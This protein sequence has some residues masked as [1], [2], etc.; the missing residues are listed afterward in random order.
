MPANSSRW[1]KGQSGNPGGR[2]KMPSELR[3][4][5]I[6][7][8]FKCFEVLKRIMCDANEKTENVLKAVAMILDRAFG[9]VV[10]SA[11]EDDIQEKAP[12]QMNSQEWEAVILDLVE[13]RKKAAA[14]SNTGKKKG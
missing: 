6:S 1:V 7:E 4:K 8:A 12:N 14:K 11:E 10:Q 2:P 5:F 3:Q 13:E 9:K